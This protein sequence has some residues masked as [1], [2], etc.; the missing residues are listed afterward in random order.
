[1]IKDSLARDD[2]GGGGQPHLR[3]VMLLKAQRNEDVPETVQRSFAEEFFSE[4]EWERG[5]IRAELVDE[6]RAIHR[7][8]KANHFLDLIRCQHTPAPLP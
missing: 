2:S 7:G 1:V 3:N 4:I 6:G 8:H 5:A